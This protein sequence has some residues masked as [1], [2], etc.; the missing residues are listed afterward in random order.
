MYITMYIFYGPFLQNIIDKA[1]NIMILHLNFIHVNNAC[2]LIASW[3]S[4]YADT[5]QL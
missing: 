4:T 1:Q 2:F 5:A 3:I